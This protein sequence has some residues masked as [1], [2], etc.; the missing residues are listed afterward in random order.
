MKLKTKIII[1]IAILI[2]SFFVFYNPEDPIPVKLHTVDKGTVESTVA[3]TRAG[4][5]K[6]C[7][8]AKLAPPMGG[9]VADLKVKEG[10]KVVKDQL[11]LELWNDDLRAQVFLAEK[12]LQASNKQ[13][14]EICLQADAALR[15]EKR[16]VALWK[17]KLTSE[18]KADQAQTLT[19][20]SR[21]ACSAAKSRAEVSVA[22]LD[23]ANA[24][25]ERTRLRAPFAGSIAEI[26]GEVGEFITPSPPGIPTPPAVDVVDTTCLYILAPI[27]EVDAPAI[28]EGMEARITLDA[29]PD[30]FFLGAVRRIAPYVFEVEKQARTVDI[31]AVFMDESQYKHLLP[32]YSADLEVILDTRYDVL[33]IPTEAIFD[34]DKVYLLDKSAHTIRSVRI[35]K[36]LSNWK[37]TEVIKGLSQGDRI[38][39]SLDKA[40]LKEGILVTTEN[41]EE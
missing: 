24:T 10:D 15:E 33:W 31:E 7:R 5:V 38:V 40:G 8:R 3:N 34:D 12:E 2:L 11:L 28:V 19:K 35:V 17:E 29:F 1:A 39:L 36:G 32:G 26:N 6:A 23:A 16:V 13:A 9:Q 37:A 18:D 25:L 20:T 27:D 41:S 22:R 4:T 14:E 30:Q 21:A